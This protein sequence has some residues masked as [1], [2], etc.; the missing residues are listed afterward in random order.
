MGFFYIYCKVALLKGCV[1]L[2][3]QEGNKSVHYLTRSL[4]LALWFFLIL[5]AKLSTYKDMPLL[6]QFYFFACW[7]VKQFPSMFWPLHLSSSSSSFSSFFL[8]LS[9]SVWSEIHYE[10]H[11]AVVLALCMKIKSPLD[12]AE[13]QGQRT[14][15][16]LFSLSITPS[17]ENVP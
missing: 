7:E 8:D 6:F 9:G 1:K 10:V 2:L 12:Y 15:S 4:P 16:S 17:C 3:S 14:D 5:F 11:L 13:P